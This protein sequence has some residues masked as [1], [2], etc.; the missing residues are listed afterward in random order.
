MLM[1]FMLLHGLWAE[2]DP[3]KHILAAADRISAGADLA[4]PHFGTGRS[5]FCVLRRFVTFCSRRF[6]NVLHARQSQ[7]PA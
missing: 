3:A 7:S 4:K 2:A 5:P 1:F 6:N